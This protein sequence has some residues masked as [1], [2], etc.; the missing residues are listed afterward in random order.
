MAT[1]RTV[2]KAAVGAGLVTSFTGV[3]TGIN[4]LA[5][6]KLRVRK[7]L[8]DLSPDD[9]D[10]VVYRDF[11]HYMQQ[12]DQSKPVSWLQYS[13]M[14][15]NIDTGKYRYCPHG[16]WYFLP[17]HR[18]FV[19]MYENAAR[20]L[21]S[22]PDFAMPYWNWTDN[23]TM[24]E[25]FADPTYKGKPNALFVPNRHQLAGKYA[26]TDH[27][28]GPQYFTLPGDPD[29]TSQSVYSETNFEV[30]GTS[31]NPQQKDTKMKWVRA[32]GGYQGTLESLPHNLVH[33]NIGAFMPTP[34][35]PR[36]PVFMMHHSHIDGIWTRWNAL[37]RSNSTDSLWLD[38]V[39]KDNYIDPAGKFYSKAV[40]ELLDTNALGYTYD[41][42]PQND[43]V[44]EAPARQQNLLALFTENPLLADQSGLR[45]FSADESEFMGNALTSLTAS[46]SMPTETMTF[47]QDDSPKQIYALIGDI[48][49]SN[50]VTSVRVFINHPGPTVSTGADDP[51]FVTELSFL[52]HAPGDGKGMPSAMVDLSPTLQ[53]LGQIGRLSDDDIAVQLLPVP[54]PGQV[55][56]EKDAVMA[57]SVEIVAL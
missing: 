47:S 35:S 34:G 15:G 33:N 43:G 56:S 38:M 29:Y 23:R 11:V 22:A 26:L 14:H 25:A 50:G 44:I 41:N 55:V 9:D 53:A 46:V 51:H 5:N 45:R 19:L 30:F 13:L 24:P 4:A 36:D 39:F 3:L 18:E 27:I 42:L 12:Q 37:G 48:M 10:V 2:L 40:N 49:L 21:L 6:T 16:D 57:G 17:W 28:V 8:A 52:S 54:V 1:R 20:E 32:G 7:N 31:R